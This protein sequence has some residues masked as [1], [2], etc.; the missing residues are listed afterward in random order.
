LTAIERDFTPITDQRASAAYRIG[1][2]RALVRKA[3]VE[4]GGTATRQTRV[5]GIREMEDANA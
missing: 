1:V 3:L 4:V 2:S 5:V